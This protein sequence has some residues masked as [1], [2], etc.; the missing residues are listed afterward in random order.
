MKIRKIAYGMLTLSLVLIVSGGFSQFLLG[1]RN[2]KRET[3]NRMF[4][5][6]D[7]FE[8]FSTNTSVFEEYRDKL[9]EDVLEGMVCDSIVSGD[10]DIKNKL[11]NYENLVDELEGNTLKLNKLC[12]DAYYPDSSTNKKCM[13]YK[14]I[15]EQVVNYFVTDINNYNN[16][17]KKCNSLISDENSKIKNYKTKKKYIDYNNDGKYD[18][19]IKTV[20]SK[21]NFKISDKDN[22]QTIAIKLKESQKDIN[23]WMITLK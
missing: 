4:Y 21:D 17:I 5:V 1:L 14:S 12:E 8:I 11:S 19:C 16:N 18:I 7:E 20:M 13:N 10:K 3:L 22:K 6:N 2:D 9:Y 15:Y 23:I